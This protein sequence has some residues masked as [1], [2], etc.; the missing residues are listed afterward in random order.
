MSFTLDDARG[1]RGGLSSYVPN[2]L[3]NR[4]NLNVGFKVLWIIALMC[5]VFIQVVLDGLRAAWPGRGT[6]TALTAIGVGRGILRGYADTETDDHYAAR[7]RAWRETWLGAGGAE[8]II[9]Q[10]HEYTKNRPLIRIITRAGNWTTID[11]DGTITKYTATWDWDSISNPERAGFWSDEWVV[12][13][14]DPWDY[15]FATYNDGTTWGQ[16]ELGIAHYDTRQEYGDLKQIF[17]TWKAA[18]SNIRCVIFTT[19]ATLFQPAFPASCPD[20]TW[21]QWGNGS[22]GGS[23]VAG[24]RN[25]LTC[26]YWE[27]GAICP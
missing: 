14:P 23:R 20:G 13:Y 19:D 24:G 8:A 9:T 10:A 11:T 12:V 18:H 5:D 16:D 15:R 26:R 21:G 2:W 7:L 1:L 17:A 22:G 25:L 27:V 3:S 4:R 6:P